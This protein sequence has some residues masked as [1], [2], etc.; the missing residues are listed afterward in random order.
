MV[1]MG[2]GVA[3][4]GGGRR[5]TQLELTK[6]MLRVRS[7]ARSRGK[8]MQ[9]GYMTMRQRGSSS[10]SQKPHRRGSCVDCH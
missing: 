3:D 9:I 1:C 2:D 10:T 6:M 4:G 5:D 8:V 7:K